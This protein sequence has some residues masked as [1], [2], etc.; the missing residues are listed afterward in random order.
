MN[1]IHKPQI[2][3][4][5]SLHWHVWVQENRYRFTAYSS[6]VI[7]VIKILYLQMIPKDANTAATYKNPLVDMEIMLPEHTFKPHV[8]FLYW[9]TKL[10][11]ILFY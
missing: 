8:N 1:N 5:H 3:S 7:L 9:K 11:S 4:V 10:V 6:R 2:N